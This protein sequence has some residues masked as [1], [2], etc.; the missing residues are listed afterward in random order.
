M[1]KKEKKKRSIRVYSSAWTCV[2]LHPSLWF[3]R[4]P[5]SIKKNR[6]DSGA[7]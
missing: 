2:L 3:L 6:R 1:K 5:F 7:F 4:L